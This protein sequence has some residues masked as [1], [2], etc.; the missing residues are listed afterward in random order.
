MA[1]FVLTVRTPHRVVFEQPVDALRVPAEDGQVGLHPRVE[2]MVLAV[3]PG[4]VVVRK[5]GAERFIATAGGMLQADTERCG[6]LTPFAV[7]G[8][9]ETEVLQA[10]DAVLATPD[11]ELQ[12]RRQLGELEQR[13]IHE[14]REE[15]GAATGR[16]HDAG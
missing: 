15:Q 11:S 9:S 6:L 12:A 8:D 14:L 5:D 2:P 16:V 7:S 4:L 1:D 3:E 10:L 13:I